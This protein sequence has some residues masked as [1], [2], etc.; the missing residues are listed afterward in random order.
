MGSDGCSQAWPGS[1]EGLGLG[2]LTPAAVGLPCDG[3]PGGGSSV[4]AASVLKP[5]CSSSSKGDVV[6]G[7]E[8]M[9]VSDKGKEEGGTRS[10]AEEGGW[11][12][13]PVNGAAGVENGHSVVENGATTVKNGLV[14]PHPCT[15]P[16]S[17]TTECAFNEAKVQLATVAPGSLCDSAVSRMNPLKPGKPVACVLG[18][19]TANPDTIRPQGQ[20]AKEYLSRVGCHHAETQAK[21]ERICYHTGID[22]RHMVLPWDTIAANPCLQEFG[23]P[24]LAMRQDILR[25]E[26][27]KLAAAACERALAEWGGNRAGVGGAGGWE[28]ASVGG[29]GGVGG[30]GA[31]AGG[32]THL[33]VVTVSGVHLPGLD[34]Q[35]VEALGLRRSTQRVLL[36]MLGCYAGVTALRIA[37][38]LAENN[39]D[40]GARVLLVCSELNSLIFQAPHESLPDSLVCAAIFG[41]G[42]AAMV[43]GA[44]PRTH[45]SHAAPAAPA[46]NTAPAA[47]AL[48][49]AATSAQ[50][51]Q[52]QQGGGASSPPLSPSPPAGIS[53]EKPSF[54]IVRVAEFFLPETM[55]HIAGDLTEAGLLVHLR[56]EV[57][58]LL[59]GPVKDFSAA[60][61][62]LAGV[63]FAES[64]WAVHP[65]GR[66]IL[67][68]IQR[69]LGLKKHALRASR[70]VLRQY[71]NM[72]SGSVLFVLD[73]IRRKKKCAEPQWG[74]ALG[75]SATTCVPR[76]AVTVAASPT[77]DDGIDTSAL[78]TP[79][80]AVAEPV[81]LLDKAVSLSTSSQAA[82]SITATL[83][84]SA[85]NVN[86]PVDV[87]VAADGTSFTAPSGDA[88]VSLMS[89]SAAPSFAEA[90]SPYELSSLEAALE[91]QP[92]ILVVV[93]SV[94]VLIYLVAGGAFF[95]PC[96]AS[97]SCIA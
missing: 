80:P 20:F 38:D 6:A 28:A 19:G 64:F 35:L 15:N 71:G 70:E 25:T 16:S 86:V 21:F 55:R 78:P 32:I 11:A 13:W 5:C 24:S 50:Q 73:E 29:V 72:S 7:I 30:E 54:E 81:G 47:P 87:S 65:G 94:L 66:A 95:P 93:A 44:N 23:A 58:L 33:V 34:V 77:P 76:R 74:V 89:S 17:A 68:A 12:K 79:S 52:Q 57:P 1:E 42:A 27:V 9:G 39:A 45:T 46:V 49:E 62:G 26:G 2:P 31:G 14:H 22:K 96:I 36:Q 75:R 61:L 92:A 84:T 59:P 82:P 53:P 37:K 88:S 69:Q 91:Q 63:G 83:A 43:V 60:L 41:D 51:Q 85:D 56:R 4:S 40:E 10:G 97:V 67:D 48:Q 8:R 90:P 3:A 18:I